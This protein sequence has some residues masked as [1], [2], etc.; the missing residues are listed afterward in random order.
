MPGVD[1]AELTAQLVRCASVTPAN[2]G[3]LE[4]L[5]DLLT[6]AG[7]D[8]AWADRGGISNLFA[9]WGN[10]GNTRSF[11][12]NGHTD[13]VPIG[14]PVDWSMPPFGAEIKDG[15]MF[16]RGTT[17]MKSGVAAFAAAA[18]DFVKDT[19][20]D[21]SIILTI[22]GDEEGDAL[23]GT[24]ALL[25][26]MKNNGER[27]DVCLVGEPTCPETM[28][29][30]MKIGR[31]GSMNAR[32][33]VTGVQGHSAYPH[34]ANNP[35][36]AMVRLMDRL[37]SHELDQGT[38]HFDASTL[39]IVTVDTGN[40]ATNV[41]PASCTAGLNIRFNDL[42]SGASLTTWLEQQNALIRDEFGVEISMSVKI[43]G[44]SFITPP[45]PLSDMIGKAVEAETGVKPVLSTSGGTSDARFVKHHCPV[46]EF[47]LVGQSM[48]KVDEHVKVDHIHQLK[49]IYGRI[50]RD[51]FA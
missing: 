21:G 45:G 50:L 38:D 20:P 15:I 7:F 14:N 6:E 40:P 12:F 10:K 11:G 13:V 44:E 41:I 30:M 26:Y 28:G 34:R 42:H 36:N 27:M 9:R 49:A 32:V 23:D 8:C 2:E 18:V 24:T 37:A 4:I 22:T 51:Y 46:V 29:E 47:G 3:A 48:H 33:T 5:H 16:G 31:R 1:P 19:P 25:E 43:S 35:L 17:D 39:A